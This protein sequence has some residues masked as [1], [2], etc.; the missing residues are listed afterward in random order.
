MTPE[1]ILGKNKRAFLP[2]ALS[3]IYQ[4]TFSH[5]ISHL[6]ESLRAQDEWLGHSPIESGVGDRRRRSDLRRAGPAADI[7]AL[8]SLDEGD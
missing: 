6:P 8:I 2:T 1:I 7:P 4:A 3:D 5:L